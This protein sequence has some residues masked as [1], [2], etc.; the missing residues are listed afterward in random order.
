M[1]STEESCSGTAE[2]L[3]AAEQRS[4][5][6]WRASCR[7][8]TFPWKIERFWVGNSKIS[9]F[10]VYNFFAIFQKF[11]IFCNNRQLPKIYKKTYISSGDLPVGSL[12]PFAKG[13]FS[14]FSFVIWNFRT[15]FQKN[16]VAIPTDFDK[17]S[18][19]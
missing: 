13:F 14:I 1:D 16:L 18:L 5:R 9:D 2:T 19:P 12:N 3:P 8:G 17:P 11:A 4:G 10:L 15:F 7:L 6:S